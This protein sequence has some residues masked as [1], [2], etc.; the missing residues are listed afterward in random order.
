MPTVVAVRFKPV[1]KIYHFLPPNE[2]E[3]QPGDPVIVETARGKE[4]GWVAQNDVK[5]SRKD[6]KG[7]LKRVLRRATPVDLY[8]QRE[9]S[10]READAL[11]QCKE[12]VAELGLPMKIVAAEYS[13]DGARLTFSFSAE[14]R[15]DFRDLVRLLVRSLRTRIEMRQIGAR[16]EAKIIDGYGRCGRQLC[17]SSWLTEFHPV[18]IRMAKNQQLPLAPTEISGVCGRLLCCLAYEDSMYT[19][20]RKGL[21]KV[22]SKIQTDGGSGTIKGVNILKQMVIIEVKEAGT[23]MEIA[24]DE[25]ETVEGD[26]GVQRRVKTQTLTNEQN[27][28]NGQPEAAIEFKPVPRSRPKSSSAAKPRPSKEKRAR[29]A[30][31]DSPKRETPDSSDRPKKSKSRKRRRSR[32]GRKKNQPRPNKNA[33]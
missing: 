27:G 11:E 33:D 1:T 31:S 32:S 29:S 12:K 24:L 7:Q 14:Q 6:I 21:P 30:M 20:L 3:L 2:P 8:N 25:I 15:I 19:D 13:F 22:G 16:D 9:Y 28:Q 4:L 23:R 10:G 17:C 18:S 5:I 26:S